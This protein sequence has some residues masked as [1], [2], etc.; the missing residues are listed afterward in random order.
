MS[1]IVLVRQDATDIPEADRE[2]ARRVLCGAI[3]GL[4]EKGKRQWR[5]LLK[6]L[7]AMEPGECMTLQRN[8][9]RSGPFHRRHMAMEQRF[10]EA[11]ERFTSFDPGFRDW[12]KIG[13][14]HCEWVPGPRGGI[15]PIPLSISYSD[16]DEDAMREFHIACVAFLRQD[17]AQKT[18][19]RHLTVL[20]RQEMVEALLLEFGEP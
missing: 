11:Q 13:A 12:L 4:G 20:Q 7:F 19:W 17:Y 5:R 3:D 8:K 15:V 10:F 6:D 18:L 9:Q 2:A 16:M 14:G 1:E